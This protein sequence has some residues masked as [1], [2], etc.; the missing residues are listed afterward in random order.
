MAF[1]NRNNA[2]LGPTL[3]GRSDSLLGYTEHSSLMMEKR[4][5]FL[6]SYQFCRKQS[7]SERMKR[8]LVK[9][10]KGMWLRLRS[11]RKLR[12]LVWSRLRFAFYCRRR[13]RFLRLLSPNHHNSYSSSSC[14]W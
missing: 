12:R 7:L 9:I 6:R 4:Q 1:V 10:K 5:L 8:S 14:F 11:A 13:R 3:V 2:H